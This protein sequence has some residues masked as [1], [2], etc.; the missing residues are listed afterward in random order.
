MKAHRDENHP[1][2]R[3][4][5]DPEHRRGL[6]R[7][8]SDL[9]NDYR[10]ALVGLGVADYTAE[11]CWKDYRTAALHCLEYAFV[12]AGSL[13]PGNERVGPSPKRAWSVRARRSSISICSV[14]FHNQ[15]STAHRKIMQLDN[16]V[17]VITGG[18]RGIG[19]GIARPS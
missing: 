8:T 2:R 17:A 11:Q 4:P 19:F 9:V 14:G 3:I 15:S 5:A 13:E 12:I 7:A 1:L 6:R 10:E 18:T 16:K